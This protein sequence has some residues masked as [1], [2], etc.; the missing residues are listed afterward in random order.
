MTKSITNMKY[1]LSS[2]NIPTNKI[3]VPKKYLIRN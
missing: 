1:K 2:I 3:K